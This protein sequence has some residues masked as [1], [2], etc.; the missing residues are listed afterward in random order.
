MKKTT[1]LLLTLCMLLSLALTACGS[2]ETNTD[3]GSNTANEG[4]EKVITTSIYWDYQDLDPATFAHKQPN[5]IVTS[6]YETLLTYDENLQLVPVLAEDWS[7]SEDGLEY[8]FYLRKGVQFHKNYGE[9]KASDVVFTFQ[10]MKDIGE[11]STAGTKMKV[12]NFDVTAEDDYTVKFTLK[13]PDPTFTMNLTLWCGFIVSEAAIND[14]GEAFN[15]TPVGTGPYE[16]VDAKFQEFC[17]MQKFD[18]YWGTPADVDRV[19]TYYITDSNTM[20]AAFDS[21]ELNMINSED[22]VRTAAYKENPDYSVLEGMSNQVIGFGLNVGSGPLADIR[23]REAIFYAVD[24]DDFIDNYY[25]GQQAKTHSM[26]PESCV[27]ADLDCFQQEYNI[28]KAKQLLADAG[29]PDGFELTIG[30]Y[31]DNRQGEAVVLQNY[32]SK[33][34]IDAKVEALEMAAWGDKAEAG[35]FDIWYVGFSCSVVP[36][37]FLVRG[38]RSDGIFNY[39]QFKDAKYDELLDAATNAIDETERAANYTAVQEY[40]R[41]Q[42]VYYPMYTLKKTI[43]VTNNISGDCF[44]ILRYPYAFEKLTM[45]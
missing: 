35:G 43:V 42:F 27:Y 31:N 26:V 37:D 24:I 16:F 8:T 3:D 40:L 29:Y 20:Y 13:Q 39:S 30:C 44:N 19:V 1:V 12:D 25:E 28:E 14:L 33:I 18:G 41:D 2:K 17:E 9:L 6:I 38:F 36:D 21:G 34:G 11:A 32:L 10:R 7:V 15:R 22:G 5:G 23:V 45:K 4:G